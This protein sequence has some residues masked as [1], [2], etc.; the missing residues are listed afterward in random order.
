MDRLLKAARLVKRGET[1]VEIS[2]LFTSGRVLVAGS[3]K[4]RA[5]FE[6]GSYREFRFQAVREADDFARLL[7]RVNSPVRLS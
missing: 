1:E 4:P 2:S 3:V 7:S 5:E 6:P